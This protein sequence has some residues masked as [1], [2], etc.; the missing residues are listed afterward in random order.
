MFVK[1]MQTFLLFLGMSLFLFVTFG[2]SFYIMLHGDNEARYENP[3]LALAMTSTLFVGQLEFADIPIN[4]LYI[5]QYVRLLAYAFFLLVFLVVMVLLNLL[6]GLA[7]SDVAKIEDEAEFR[8]NY[9][10]LE[11]IMSVESFFLQSKSK[12]QNKRSFLRNMFS[13]NFVLPEISFFA[14]FQMFDCCM[15]R[16]NTSAGH[17]LICPNSNSF[18]EELNKKCQGAHCNITKGEKENSAKFVYTVQ[19][20]KEQSP[21]E[22][23]CVNKLTKFIITETKKIIAEREIKKQ[24]TI[25]AEKKLDEKVDNLENKIDNLEKILQQDEKY[26]EK[27]IDS[28]ENK[29]DML[30]KIMK[31]LLSIKS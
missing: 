20:N 21:F 17:V 26:L 6:N 7:V 8:V 12:K 24:E 11:V 13:E 23:F 4:D 18:L 2:F 31:Q 14:F 16:L 22:Y 3:F 5:N 9:N 15:E 25:K 1:V 29:I 27:K 10:K 19:P 30:E 28:L